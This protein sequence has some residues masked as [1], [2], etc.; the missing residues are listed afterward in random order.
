M[1]TTVSG[2]LLDSKGLHK[3]LQDWQLLKGLGLISL[4]KTSSAIH[5]LRSLEGLFCLEK[6]PAF[7]CSSSAEIQQGEE[8]ARLGITSK[9]PHIRNP[10]EINIY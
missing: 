3:P 4:E 1:K 8:I 6:L 10:E 7:L 9:L 2:L 5:G